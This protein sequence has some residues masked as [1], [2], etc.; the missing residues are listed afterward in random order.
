M[1]VRAPS[2]RAPSVRM[3]NAARE[4]VRGKHVNGIRVRMACGM[5]SM[6]VSVRVNVRP[7]SVH[8]ASVRPASVRPARAS[9]PPDR[10]TRTS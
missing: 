4:C 1:S 10:S 9:A 8:P 3:A 7:A 2:L 5:A 6:R